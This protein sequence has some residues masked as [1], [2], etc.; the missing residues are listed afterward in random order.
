MRTILAILL[1]CALP[2]HAEF[3]S[4]ADLFALMNGD[5][6]QKVQA[7]NYIK[8]AHDAGQTI[9]HCAPPL[10][11]AQLLGMVGYVLVHG[12]ERSEWSA[13]RYVSAALAMA[14]PCRARSGPAKGYT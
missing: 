3:L 4:G 1:L 11:D 14:F 7:L 2:A 8:G 12:P 6:A 13:D 9:A 5:D 10:S